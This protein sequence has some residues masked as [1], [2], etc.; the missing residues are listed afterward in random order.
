MISPLKRAKYV[1]YK[2]LALFWK[3]SVAQ[4]TKDPALPQLCHPWPRNFHMLQKQAKP[5]GMGV[6]SGSFLY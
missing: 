4:Q 1:E 6:E 2:N 5:W 3:F